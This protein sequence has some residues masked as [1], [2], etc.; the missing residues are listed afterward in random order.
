MKLSDRLFAKG[1]FAQGIGFPTVPRDKARVRTIVTA[2]HTR[3]EL[4]FALDVFGAVGREL[5]IIESYARYKVQSAKKSNVTFKSLL[6]ACCLLPARR[7][8]ADPRSR[9]T[10]RRPTAS[11]RCCSGS[12]ASSS[13]ATPQ[14]YM[15]AVVGDRRPERRPRFRASRA[16]RRA[17]PGW[18]CANAIAS[19]LVGT[20]PGNGYRLT[21]DVFTE[22]G[23]RARNAT[24]RLDVKRVG[25]RRDEV[26]LIADQRRF[27]LVE[28][29][30][31]LS[32]NRTKQFAA[33]DLHARARRSR[34]R[35]SPTPRCSSSR[36]AEGTTGL[37]LLGRGEVRFHPTP[38]IEKG[39]LKIFCG[40][41]TLQTRI[42]T[43][44]VR[45]NPDDVEAL[46][47]ADRLIAARRRSTRLRRAEALFREEV[48]KSYAVDM[49]DLSRDLWSLMPASG[50]F[51]AEIHTAA[52]RH[53]DLRAVEGGSGR[54]LVLRPEAAAEHRRLRLQTGPGPPR[55]LVQRGRVGR[56]RRA[57]LRPRRV[58][59]A[60]SAVDRRPRA[61]ST[62]GAGV[63]ADD[64]VAAA[65]R[66]A[67]RAVDRQRSVRPA[68]RP[69]RAQPEHDH[70]QSAGVPD[71]RRAAAA[72]HRLRR[73][74]ASRSAR[75]RKRSRR[76]VRR[77]PGSTQDDRGAAV[78]ARTQLPVQQP[79][80]LVSAG[81]GHRLR[82]RQHP[83]DGAGPVRRASPAAT[84]TPVFRWRCPGRM[85]RAAQ[86][87]YLFTT[88]EPLRYLAFIVSRFVR[89]EPVVGRARVRR[90][91]RSR[92]AGQPAAGAPRPRAR[93]ARR[94]HRR[95]STRRSSAIVRTPASRWRWWKASCPA[96]TAPDTSSP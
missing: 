11:A 59:V 50:D 54:H 6:F 48:Q 68:V 33:R 96:A 42:D 20:L 90:A 29:L 62:A 85:P 78:S 28:N 38:E 26:W 47:G 79:E 17:R 35:A 87:V 76:S 52:V 9:R 80:L 91:A 63:G 27:A 45:V 93:A 32:L 24:W 4:Q 37:V 13:R 89:S 75:T 66:I 92:R 88:A 14:A 56:L 25:E 49:S 39:Q 86:K 10:R 1:V 94:R 51:L 16:R 58:D 55:P 70:R 5:G 44:F 61:H 40:S 19:A 30:H 21:L 84:S 81:A 18:S 8:R 65:G 60:R 22:F 23:N 69:A 3:E 41:E 46:V 72:D 7:S 57:R 71:S 34:A 95:S 53:A 77:A 67:G 73:P 83:R 15:G 12:S 43:V 2:T 82:D 64:A 74:A 31:R 36:P